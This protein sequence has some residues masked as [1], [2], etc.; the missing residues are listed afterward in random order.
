MVGP[1]RD[2]GFYA[3]TSDGLVVKVKRF[4]HRPDV[5][6]FEQNVLNPDSCNVRRLETFVFEG[7]EEHEARY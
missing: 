6:E 1:T 7:G 3:L 4:N 5:R 2:W